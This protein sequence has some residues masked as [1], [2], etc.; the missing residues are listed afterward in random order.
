VYLHFLPTDAKPA[1][2]VKACGLLLTCIVASFRDNVASV[3]AFVITLFGCCKLNCYVCAI[4]ARSKCVSEVQTFAQQDT[5]SWSLVGCCAL[6]KVRLLGRLALAL[7]SA[8]SAALSRL[9][10]LQLAFDWCPA[11]WQLDV[12]H[13][14]T[15][16]VMVVDY[17]CP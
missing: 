10:P 5:R 16:S 14:V 9:A 11:I 17:T 15:L 2:E 13:F 8:L 1:V 3:C 6:V 7:L 4:V 12:C